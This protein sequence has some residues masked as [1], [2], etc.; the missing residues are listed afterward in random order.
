MIKLRNLN[1]IQKAMRSHKILEQSVC[2]S[3]WMGES[4][5]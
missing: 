3:K 5:T 2:V 1:F 4:E